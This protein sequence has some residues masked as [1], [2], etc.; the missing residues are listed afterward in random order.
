MTVTAYHKF[1]PYSRQSID[2]ADIEAVKKVLSS[3][4]LTT[5][6]MIPKFEQALGATVQS[7]YVLAL[8]SGTAP[9]HLAL[10]AL[11]IGPGD[12][13]IVPAITFV[14]TANVVRACQAEVIFADVDP[15][16]G[17]MRPE[18]LL[19]ALSQKTL[20]AVRAVIPVH[21]TGQTENLQEIYRIAKENHLF[22]IEDACHAL[23]AD[24]VFGKAFPI[25]RSHFSDA[26]AFSF[27]A[28]KSIAMGEGGALLTER[29]EVF[30]YAEQLRSHGI[31]RSVDNFVYQDRSHSQ[32][33]ILNPWYYEMNYPGFNYRVSDIHCAL[34]LSQLKR[35]P[36]FIQKRRKLAALYDHLLLPLMPKLR[37]IKKTPYAQSSYHLY[38]V[39]IDFNTI[40]R[41][42]AVLMRELF[43]KQIGSQVHYIPVHQQPY[44]EKRYGEQVLIGAETYYQKTLSL[45]LY[46]TMDEADVV[47]VVDT[48]TQLLEQ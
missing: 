45:P 21:L 9:L 39:L 18:D 10:L 5:G 23:G 11:G 7:R 40:H 16:T 34:G 30:N 22:V 24:Y 35:L 28:V 44:Y 13:V 32:D 3:D 20:N 27:H 46:P 4:F 25:G 33:N 12:A 15:E 1:L 26:V 31:T 2:E 37:P 6:P 43:A 42:R 8:N 47:Y 29:E 19:R 48:L 36:Q 17:L 41:S 14:A 38:S